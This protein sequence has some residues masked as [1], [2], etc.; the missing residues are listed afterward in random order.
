MQTG[1]AQP[2][3]SDSAPKVE[4]GSASS[5]RPACSPF[6][7]KSPH[8]QL[9]AL[10]HMLQ[11]L[12]QRH[13]KAPHP[14]T[15]TH[16]QAAKTALLADANGLPRALTA[17]LHS[18]RVSEEAT[19]ASAQHANPPETVAGG[20]HMVPTAAR[21]LD[22][23]P[24]TT[25]G[26]GTAQT[27]A[28]G[29][30]LLM[31]QSVSASKPQGHS[32]FRLSFSPT[33]IPTVDSSRQSPQTN[34]IS[35][36]SALVSATHSLCSTESDL[37]NATPT[38]QS[39]PLSHATQPEAAPAA[40]AQDGHSKV[41]SSGA[42][43]DSNSGS[44]EP[45]L[46]SGTAAAAQSSEQQPQQVTKASMDEV[47][48]SAHQEADHPL[49]AEASDRGLAEPL[50][51]VSTSKVLQADASGT[52]AS[53]SAI[54]PA[55]ASLPFATGALEYPASSE[56]H[57]QAGL[58]FGEVTASQ[59]QP[60]TPCGSSAVLLPPSTP[61]LTWL[62][63]LGTPESD[64]QVFTHQTPGSGSADASAFPGQEGFMP[65]RALLPLANEST[66]GLLA[67]S[68]EG[69]SK[70]A[71]CIVPAS[72]PAGTEPSDNSVAPPART[73]VNGFSQDYT[74]LELTS[75]TP[76][77]TEP[78][79]LSQPDQTSLVPMPKQ[80]APAALPNRANPV[81][82]LAG[83]QTLQATPAVQPK[84]ATPQLGPPTG[85]SG[86]TTPASAAEMHRYVR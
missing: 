81:W 11:A 5:Q 60:C 16:T 77:P 33:G 2:G 22:R 20:L 39:T 69:P 14:A 41:L 72:R 45:D 56:A 44:A 19:G 38:L 30:M 64:S 46:E 3:A 74:P 57:T 40:P 67:A 29:S 10:E 61:M 34:D 84:Q 27:A 50:G 8:G 62:D 17:S 4:G 28:L 70:A 9:Q 71:S 49:A 53:S 86:L 79:P 68:S 21:H 73:K 31:K 18:T 6:S 82:A 7:C 66:P 15:A 63:A 59:Q 32:A 48:H 75:P 24:T 37:T 54:S 47:D 36:D 80:A 13:A 12:P 52:A 25:Q 65:G 23:A 43:L 35:V 83:M 55:S 78:V 42:H 76:V 85:L 58:T 1:Q 51:P 26:G